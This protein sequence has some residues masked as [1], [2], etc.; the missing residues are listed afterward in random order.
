MQDKETISA[1]SDCF[2]VPG[3]IKPIFNFGFRFMVLLLKMSIKTELLWKLFV[4]TS[5][6]NVKAF[7]RWNDNFF[8]IMQLCDIRSIHVQHTQLLNNT[9]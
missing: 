7:S 6:G 2:F 5:Q 4:P 1:F 8:I 3:N 9:S